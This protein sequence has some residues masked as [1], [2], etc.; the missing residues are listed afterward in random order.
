[1]MGAMRALLVFVVALLCAVAPA[2]ADE[3][4]ISAERLTARL[5]IEALA[6]SS[7]GEWA[8]DW[9]PVSARVSR[10]MHWHIFE[11]DPRDRPADYVAR[12]NGWIDAPGRDVSVSVFGGEQRVGELSFTFNAR[13]D[14][15]LVIAALRAEGAGVDVVRETDESGEYRLAIAE[16]EPAV[17]RVE[18][19][20]TSP[21]SAAAQ[22]CWSTYT[23]R[24]D[25]SP[26]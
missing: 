10:H 22:R 19:R 11:P 8:Y 3:Q 9:G 1:M 12:R 6:P 5:M 26:G 13:D 16:H 15:L 25:P 2:R 20:C 7:Y 24:F 14:E 17:L 23:L 21:R 18:H 4:A